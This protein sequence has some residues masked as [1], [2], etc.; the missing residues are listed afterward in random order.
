MKILVS[1]TKKREIPSTP[2][3]NEN[4]NEGIKAKEYVNWK[5]PLTSSKENHKNKDK[6]NE[7]TVENKDNSYINLFPKDPVKKITN[8]VKIG[9]NNIYIKISCGEIKIKASPLVK[10]EKNVDN[11]A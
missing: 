10:I 3:R 11:I 5:P 8:I 9:T 2:K 7:I 4:G 1:K 6:R